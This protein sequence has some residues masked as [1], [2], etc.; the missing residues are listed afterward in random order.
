MT[1]SPRTRPDVTGPEIMISV[2]APLHN[3]EENLDELHRRLRETLDAL[4]LGFELLL[5]ND[6]SVDGTARRLDALAESDPS[7]LPLHLSRNFGHQAAVSAGLARAVGRVVVVMDGDLQDPPEVL[8]LFLERWREGYDVVYAIR[9]AR[10]ESLPKRAAYFLFYRALAAIS[11]LDIPL[12]SGDFALM[13]RKV[14]DAL[15]ALPE[16]RRF[17]RG[18]RSFVGFRQTG[19]AYERS[20]RGAGRPKY[21]FAG[22]V[23]LAVDGLISFSGYPLRLVTYLGLATSAVAAALLV[24]VLVDALYNHTAPRGWASTVLVVL[25][26]GSVQ[27]I[28]M[29]I[30]GEYI[31]LIFLEV[32]RRPSYIVDEGRVSSTSREARRP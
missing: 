23:G 30:I 7:V 20:A 2:V 24:W 18:L 11:D 5:V 15:N 19:L 31:R 22:L 13:D 1:E 8:P 32:K 16:Q 6:G 3:E 12:D 4:G 17:V 9:T 29:G 27:L 28:G 25:F 14:V 26:M 21:T 10:K